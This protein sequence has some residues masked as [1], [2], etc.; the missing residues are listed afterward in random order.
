M[1]R[2]DF[3][4]T[5]RRAASSVVAS[6]APRRSGI[7]SSVRSAAKAASAAQSAGQA[8]ASSPRSTMRAAATRRAAGGAVRGAARVDQAPSWA[9]RWSARLQSRCGVPMGSG[10]ELGQTFPTVRVTRG[11]RGRAARS[12]R[13][14]RAGSRGRSRGSSA[15]R[16]P[17]PGRRR[18]S[19]PAALKP[20]GGQVG[21]AGV[22][23]G[24]SVHAPEEPRHGAHRRPREIRVSGTP[25]GT[26]TPHTYTEQQTPP[27]LE[28]GRGRNSVSC[29]LFSI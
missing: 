3:G 2:H 10:G 9:G 11:L 16:R 12:R 21:L 23:T 1:R 5:P 29:S 14:L 24:G 17:R 20:G 26:R 19:I 25:S 15:R 8:S 27:L 7:A 4:V 18:R 22:A 28:R 13:R 6:S